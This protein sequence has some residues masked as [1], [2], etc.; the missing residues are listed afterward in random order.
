MNKNSRYFVIYKPYGMLTQFTDTEGRKTLA[1]LFRFPK[2][3]YPVGRLDMDSEGLLLL[4]NDNNLNH[5][6]LN[7]KFKHEREYLVQV[8]GIPDKNA[9]KSLESSVIIENKKTLPAKAKL[10]TDLPNVPERIPPIRERK[11]IPT[12]WLTLTLVEGRN[13]QVRK[14][15]AKVGYPTLRL[16][17]IRIED[18]YLDNMHPGE[19]REFD[20]KTSKLSKLYNEKKIE[21]R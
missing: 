12:S 16:I 17:R 14:M 6:L 5:Y 4:T 21:R 19:V 13:R 7:P 11:N 18:I 20:I 8:E 1:D 9:I 15:T 2:D 3:V 10:L